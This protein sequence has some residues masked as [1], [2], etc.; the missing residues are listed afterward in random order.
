MTGPHRHELRRRF[1]ALTLIAAL[2]APLPAGAAGAEDKALAE[3]LFDEAL[4]LM[5]E[6]Q[7][8][9]ACPKL[10]QS[11]RIDPGIGTL[12]YLGEC[13]ERTGRTASAWATFREA[14]SAAQ[15]AGQA[16]RARIAQERAAALESSLSRLTIEAGPETRELPDLVVKRSG[17]VLDASLWGVALPIDPGKY[18]IEVTA[19]GHEPWSTS[20]TITPQA[21]SQT[22]KIPPLKRL[23]PVGAPPAALEPAS[24]PPD[25]APSAPT[26]DVEPAS[27]GLST[28]QVIGVVTGSVGLVGLG[29]GSYFGFRAISKNSD[30]ELLCP[31]GKQCDSPKGVTLTEDAKDAA[32]VSNIAFGAGAGLVIAGMVLYFTGAN[33]KASADLHVT[34]LIA[35]NT[36]GLAVG[37]AFR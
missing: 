25:P 14:Y 13:Y 18:T 27:D 33:K 10:E 23:Q 19:P 1:T 36:G 3:A 15:A 31:R 6:G 5:K 35:G 20:V 11:G 28:Q 12:L 17:K 21:S 9:T 22:I 29:F 2:A 34:P 7:F 8:E 37:G 16:E 26:S 4:R 30:A 32:L 24:P